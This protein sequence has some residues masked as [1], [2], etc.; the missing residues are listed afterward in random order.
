MPLSIPNTFTAGT[1]AK[2]SEVNANF[3]AVEALLDG[4]LPLTELEDGSSG[5][6]II[7]NSSGVPTYR[8]PSGPLTISDT[9]VIAQ[10]YSSDG[11]GSGT[12]LNGTTYTTID[13]CTETP[14]A[15]TWL[16]LGKVAILDSTNVTRAEVQLTEAGTQRDWSRWGDFTAAAT[17]YV[18]LSVMAVLSL[19][20]AEAVALQARATGTSGSPS[21]TFG[22][23]IGIRLA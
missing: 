20:G 16:Y 6:L 5:Q 13:N 7:C 12:T 2:A 4:T 19:N 22:K 14:A 21:S 15:G 10:S 11:Q 3:D 1:K 18:T 9:G 17:E 23:L 8:T